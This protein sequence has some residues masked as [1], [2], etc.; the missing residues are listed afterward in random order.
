LF[1]RSL[2]SLPFFYVFF[3]FP[4][5][6]SVF[7]PVKVWSTL[8]F[9]SRDSPY[10]FLSFIPRNV[11]HRIFPLFFS[12]PSG[13]YPSCFPQG[14]VPTCHRSVLSSPLS[15][16]TAPP[17]VPGPPT[18]S[19]TGLPHCSPLHPFCLAISGAGGPHK[20]P[21]LPP[22]LGGLPF[23]IPPESAALL[24]QFLLKC[25]KCLLFA[26]NQSE[27]KDFPTITLIR[28]SISLS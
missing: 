20:S 27:Q 24:L 25:R 26:G 2:F 21:S 15:P 3:F 22:V 1:L 9:F 5:L 4:F 14:F 23:I 12:P 11:V 8:S 17:P 16:K 28:F 18:S 10:V 13:R 6:V 7:D 19:S